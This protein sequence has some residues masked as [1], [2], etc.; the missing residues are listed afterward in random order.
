MSDLI[1]AHLTRLRNANYSRVTIRSRADLL[2]RVDAELLLGLLDPT[3]E[4][5]QAFLAGPPDEEWCEETR[6]IYYNH[7]VGFYRDPPVLEEVGWDPTAGLIRPKVTHYLP[8]PMSD[9]EVTY[10]LANLPRPWDM[11]VAIAAYAGLRAG[12]LSR[13]ERKHISEKWILV[14]HGK[15]GK[16]RTVEMS[17][18]LWPY[19]RLL[20]TGPIALLGSGLVMTPA[21][22]SA[23]VRYRLDQIGLSDATLH[24]FRHWFATALIR[25]GVDVLVVAELMGHANPNTTKVYCLITSE[26]R[27]NAVAALPALAPTPS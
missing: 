22:M 19:V 7:L 11:Y 10:A 6:R 18:H 26:Q 3:V 1:A 20:P 17:P 27:R 21:Q 15:G 23:R 25:A 8:R 13:L 24:R 9:E 16:S 4:E 5:L 14:D 2:R 12:E